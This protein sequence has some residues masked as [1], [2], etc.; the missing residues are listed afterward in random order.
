M[1]IAELLT[2]REARS[3]VASRVEVLDKVGELA[4]LPANGWATTKQ[5][6]AFYDVAEMTVRN[7]VQDHRDELTEDG[8]RVI[9]GQEVNA[10]K[11]F[12]NSPVLKGTQRL[13]VFPRRAVLR[14]G[15]LLRDSEIAMQVRSFLLNVEEVTHPGID[16][17]V[18]AAED[19]VIDG[20]SIPDPG[21]PGGLVRFIE[22]TAVALQK[23]ADITR[24]KNA[25]E[26]QI[27]ENRPKVELHDRFIASGDRYLIRQVAKM[28]HV[29][30]SD[31]FLLL[32]HNGFIFKNRN[33][34]WEAY[35]KYC[36]HW[37]VMKPSTVTLPGGEVISPMTIQVTPEGVDAIHRRV[38]QRSA[39][40][41]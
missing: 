38:F 11:A 2:S 1:E 41:S 22:Q 31:M 6:A 37:F 34:K 12:P 25:L 24:E 16:V 33:E 7:V 3:R 9:A 19:V 15:M 32:H 36:P 18:P 39:L 14:M 28:F 17:M 5:V 20:I 23:L 8:Y 26:Q 13:A 29:R 27:E 30:P 4:T 35:S 21:T 40:T 10:L